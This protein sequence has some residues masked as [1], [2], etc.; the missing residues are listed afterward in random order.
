MMSE[1]DKKKM[2][3][4]LRQVENARMELEIR[5]EELLSEVERVKKHIE[6]QSVKE[7]ELK[8]KLAE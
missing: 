6:I 8:A 5:I 4:Q 3:L 1:L 7:E 2:N